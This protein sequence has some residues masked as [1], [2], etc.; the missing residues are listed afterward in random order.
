MV[1]KNTKTELTD[2]VPMIFAAM[3]NVMAGMDAIVK[4]KKKD[5]T[6]KYAFRSI[7]DIMNA[8]HPLLVEHKVIIV[9]TQVLNLETKIFTSTGDRPKNQFQSVL[10]MEYT[11]YSAIDGSFIV[12]QI[13]AEA[14]D[15]SDKATQ[16]ATSYTFKD[17]IQKTFCIP[18]VDMQDDGDGHQIERGDIVPAQRRLPTTDEAVS[19]AKSNAKTRED[20]SKFVEP[21]EEAASPEAWNAIR[22]LLKQ[23]DLDEAAFHSWSIITLRK[24]NLAVPE[25]MID[26]P[27]TSAGYLWKVAKA[28]Q[29]EGVLIDELPT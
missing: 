4:T 9:P 5:S 3:A 12:G 11:C 25:M 26:L 20:I 14:S 10:T 17:F 28:A 21:K 2:G 24:N 23:F 6:V 1:A 29:K 22:E 18:T 8:L 15:F 16:Q 13:A 19:E 27:K 7:E